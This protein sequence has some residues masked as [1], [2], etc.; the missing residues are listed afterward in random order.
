[1]TE[2]DMK[3][4]EFIKKYKLCNSN[5]IYKVFFNNVAQT[6]CSRR[7]KYLY[8]YGYI[9]RQKFNGNNYIYFDGKKPATR[10]I[11]HDLLITEFILKLLDEEYEILDFKKS[12]VLG[13]II[14]DAYIKIYKN[15]VVKNI[16]LEVQ[17]GTHDC[18]SK[19]KNIKRLVLDNTDWDVMPR[20]VVVGDVDQKEIQGLKISYFNLNMEGEL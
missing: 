15:N 14:P 1:M 18:I 20:L 16:L 2:R 6:V 4:V 3:V 11:Q 13:D 19:Y 9:D 10:L 17:L 12:F 5:Q 8:E 7:L